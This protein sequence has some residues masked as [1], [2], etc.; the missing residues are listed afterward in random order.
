MRYAP[1][2]CVVAGVVAAGVAIHEW[3]YHDA[4]PYASG[5]AG[6]LAV[7][8]AAVAALAAA[9]VWA[10]LELDR[11]ERERRAELD[12]L[13]L[14]ISGVARAVEDEAEIRRTISAIEAADR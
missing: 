12:Q 8:F 7:G 11:R 5:P 14:K 2:V 1:A 9:V 6:V 13:G 3:R 4:H 10:L